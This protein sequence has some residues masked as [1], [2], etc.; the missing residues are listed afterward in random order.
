M[1]KK[2]ALF[3]FLSATLN[4]SFSQD[5]F[6]TGTNQSLI[7][8]N[9]SF[10]GT[11]GFVRY[12]S[13]FRLQDFNSRMSSRTVYSG[14]DAYIK[15]LK[16]GIAFSY[17]N[18]N[19]AKGLLTTSAP[20]FCYAQ[21]IYV[22]NNAL[23]IIP[24]VQGTY[25]MKR[26]N[27]SGLNY[28][29]TVDPRKNYT[30]EPTAGT[31]FVSPLSEKNFFDLSASALIQT[32]N[33]TIGVAVCH[34]N[35]P[36]EGLTGTQ[37]LPFKMNIHGAYNFV[38][39]PD[40]SLSL[41]ALFINQGDFKDYNLNCNLSWQKELFFGLGLR[42]TNA[43]TANLAFQADAFRLGIGY[44]YGLSGIN[45]N[46]YGKSTFEIMLGFNFSNKNSENSPSAEWGTW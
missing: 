1:F 8:L 22:Y 45:A 4:Q 39:N 23:K 34:L 19:Q 35:Q 25:F 3:F 28:R 37:K 2:Y 36:D 17:L 32:K 40:L 10:A 43:L 11:N 29:D 13:V 46:I 27:L 31:N 38:L 42:K 14:L 30:F 16:A 12:Q 41:F 15:A 44:D 26:L 21:H 7:Y 5:A 33:L 18:D 24:A 6:F 20:R 9:P